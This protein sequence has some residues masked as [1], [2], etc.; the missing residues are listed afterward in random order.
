MKKNICDWLVLIYY[1]IS[2]FNNKTEALFKKLGDRNRKFES[3]LLHI[4]ILG[5]FF[6]FISVI[7]AYPSSRE[8][9]ENELF[10]ELNYYTNEKINRASVCY[11][12]F[13]YPLLLIAMYS[14]VSSFVSQMFYDET[15][16]FFREYVKLLIL[17]PIFLIIFVGILP[18]LIFRIFFPRQVKSMKI[19]IYSVFI[20]IIFPTLV[21]PQTYHY[22][23][24]QPLV[25]Q[26]QVVN[27]Y[28][29]S[30]KSKNNTITFSS[31]EKNLK[32]MKFSRLP[33]QI[34]NNAKIGDEYII[35]GK[36]SRFYFT[37]ENIKN[38][39]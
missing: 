30:R 25:I 27:I 39:I 35:Y 14:L 7:S 29:K 38:K 18:F 31:K 24:A 34:I 4:P 23:Y 12:I 21:L 9:K 6:K 13:L 20:A 15:I 36:K 10:D 19:F 3:K 16:L 37:Y 32:T 8:I 28:N 1:L 11:V 2:N 26:S 17:I 22:M 33:K 5:Y